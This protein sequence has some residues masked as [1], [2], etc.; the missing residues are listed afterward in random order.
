MIVLFCGLAYDIVWSDTCSVFS[1]KTSL[2]LQRHWNVIMSIG[3]TRWYP[4]T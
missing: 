3:V 4:S 2:W 1:R